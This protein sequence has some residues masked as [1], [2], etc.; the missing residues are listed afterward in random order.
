M[1]DPV[2]TLSTRPR[3]GLVGPTLAIARREYASFFRGPLGWVV[4]ALFLLL[5]GFVFARFAIVP[6]APA[7]M[8]DF[9]GLWWRVLVIITPAISMRLLSQEHASGTVDPLMASPAHELSIAAGKYLGA[10][11]FLLTLLAPTL[12]YAALLMALARPDPGPII[13]GYA[14]VVLLGMLQLALGLLASALTSSQTLAYLST[15]FVLVGVEMAATFGSSLAP[16]PLDAI[17]LAMSTDLRIADF[18]RGVVD[19]GHVAYFLCVSAWLV[20]LAALALR[21]RRWR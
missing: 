3:P 18:A 10:V 5:S 15:L 7:T 19:T 8:R 12:L 14:G 1:S 17:L 6:G 11:G 21:A 20:A 4:A 16:R 9:F 13:A 2:Q